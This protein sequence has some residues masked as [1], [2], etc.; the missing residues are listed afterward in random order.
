MTHLSAECFFFF[1]FF[2]FFL[3][4]LKVIIEDCLIES[5]AHVMG[6]YAPLYDHV[7]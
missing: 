6:L 4:N 2:F 1:F 7:P 5:L 3:M